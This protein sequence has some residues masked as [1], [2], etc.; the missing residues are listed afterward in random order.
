MI[1]PSQRPLPTQHTTNTTDKQPCPHW[2]SNPR[3]RHSCGFNTYVL[4]RTTTI[5]PSPFLIITK[6]NKSFIR[7]LQ[8]ICELKPRYLVTCAESVDLFR[9]NFVSRIIHFAINYNF[10]S[11]RLMRNTIYKVPL[12]N[13]TN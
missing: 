10:V 6:L 8:Y 5:L 1:S 3:S 9:D 12:K 13:L 2:D 7:L 11:G 4:D